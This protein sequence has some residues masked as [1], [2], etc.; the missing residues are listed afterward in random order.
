L[1][2]HYYDCYTELLTSR[3]CRRKKRSYNNFFYFLSFLRSKKLTS[4]G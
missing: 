2:R 3:N 4:N 1:T